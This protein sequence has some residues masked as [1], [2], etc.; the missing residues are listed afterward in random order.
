MEF[1]QVRAAILGFDERIKVQAKVAD[2]LAY[3]LIQGLRMDK[4]KLLPFDRLFPG[5]GDN[6]VQQP[7][8]PEQIARQNA[9]RLAEWADEEVD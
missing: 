7:L 5:W 8:T 9:R 1:W 6:P 4:P 3:K 2:A